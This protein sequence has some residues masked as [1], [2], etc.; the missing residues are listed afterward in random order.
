MEAE[1]MCKW[2]RLHKRGKLG[3]LHDT[4]TLISTF[5]QEIWTKWDTKSQDHTFL[6]QEKLELSMSQW[7]RFHS[8]NT[9]DMCYV[10]AILGHG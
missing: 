2:R 4:L 10:C 8:H 5:K 3:V 1:Q 6:T 7:F 9:L